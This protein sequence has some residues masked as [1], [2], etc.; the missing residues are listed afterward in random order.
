MN[1]T[2]TDCFNFWF[3][4]AMNWQAKEQ[5]PSDFV[6]LEEHVYSQAKQMYKQINPVQNTIKQK[7]RK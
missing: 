6:E 1:F 3:Y 4:F 5:F 2:N 7:I